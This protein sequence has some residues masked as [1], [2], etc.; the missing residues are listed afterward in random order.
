MVD[1]RKKSTGEMQ[2]KPTKGL[3]SSYCSFCQHLS[4]EKTKGIYISYIL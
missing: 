3:D 2:T 4:E 1:A